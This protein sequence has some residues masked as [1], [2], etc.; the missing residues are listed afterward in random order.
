M[1]AR[2]QAVGEK[3][4]E[5]TQVSSKDSKLNLTEFLS[6]PRME[7][8]QLHSEASSEMG[9]ADR[10]DVAGSRRCRSGLR[11]G[12][13]RERPLG[14]ART[15]QEDVVATASSRKLGEHF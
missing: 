1:S 12:R 14:V 3:P 2:T 8:A 4:N 15:P 5:R 10:R 13:D 6:D 7:N 9:G 11:N